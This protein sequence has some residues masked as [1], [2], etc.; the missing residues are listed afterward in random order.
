[1]ADPADTDEPTTSKL[2]PNNVGLLTSSENVNN[3]NREKEMNIQT[4]SVSKPESDSESEYESD[5]EEKATQN[6][7][8][9]FNC[10]QPADSVDQVDY[11]K[12]LNYTKDGE[13]LYTDPLSGLQ[14]KFSTTQ[15][16]WI[17]SNEDNNTDTAQ[18][19]STASNPFENEY[20]FW[21]HT[22]QQWL[23]KADHTFDKEKNMWIEKESTAAAGT[24]AENYVLDENGVRT[25]RDKDGT[26]FEWDDEKKA[27]FPKIDDDFMAYYQLNYGEYKADT[28]EKS[29]TSGEKIKEK[30]TSAPETLEDEVGSAASEEQKKDKKR[31]K[32]PEPPKWFEI[33]EKNNTKVYVENLP[34]DITEEEFV[35]LMAKYGM[36][37]KDPSTH[38]FKVKLYRDA[39]GE[40]KGDGLCTYIKVRSFKL[41]VLNS[42]CGKFSVAA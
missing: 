37:L 28:D 31:K 32:L 36:V 7:S 18:D 27:W 14:Y 25:Y 20:Y 1:M 3:E 9:S 38:K 41:F 10:T 12:H 39:N 29:S 34:L 30:P 6:D 40:V 22:K 17:P 8:Q 11:V 13:A 23:L 26:T 4:A 21:S 42:I 16:K 5:A 19:P 2:E 35:E 33:D 24:S 15:N